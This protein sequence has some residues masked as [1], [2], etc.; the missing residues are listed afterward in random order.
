MTRDP[1]V[2]RARNEARHSAVERARTGA[3]IGPDDMAAIFG[4]SASRFY[5]LNRSGAFDAF[6]TKPAIGPRCFSGTLVTKHLHGEPIFEPTF[7][8]KRRSA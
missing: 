5:E 6:K 4:Y 3:I 8:K 7:G 2:E 1:A